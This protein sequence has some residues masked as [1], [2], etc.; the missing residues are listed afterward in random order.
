MG[1]DCHIE[2]YHKSLKQNASLE[3]SPTRTLT[4]RAQPPVC[5][6]LCLRQTRSL[7]DQDRRGSL[8]DQVKDLSVGA[9]GILFGS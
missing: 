7:E 1:C 9:E 4:T 6:P 5:F 3:K 8:Y 2:V